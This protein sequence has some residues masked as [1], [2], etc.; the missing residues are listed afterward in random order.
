[1]REI[2]SYV[3]LLRSIIGFVRACQIASFRYSCAGEI[4]R[5]DATELTLDARTPGETAMFI[6]MNR[7]RVKPGSEA[8]FE[9]VWLNREVYLDAVPGFI[10]FHLPAR[11]SERGPHALFLAHGLAQPGR[12]RGLDAIGSF[13]RRAQGGRRQQTAVSGP[14]AVRGFEVLQTVSARHE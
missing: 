10:E 4:V 7:F 3:R 8:E 12:F 5:I 2:R 6:A 11:A 1:M 13:P 14:S 9:A